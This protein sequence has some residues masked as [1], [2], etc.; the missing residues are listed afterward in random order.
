MRGMNELWRIRPMAS[1]LVAKGDRVLAPWT[2]GRG[3]VQRSDP[4]FLS[5]PV[6]TVSHRMKDCRV[7]AFAQRASRFYSRR[8]AGCHRHHR[9]AAAL[10]PG[11]RA[12]SARRP[13]GVPT[14]SNRSAWRSTRIT[15]RSRP[16]RP[17]VSVR[18][19]AM[20]AFAV[21][22]SLWPSPGCKTSRKT[23]ASL[24]VIIPASVSS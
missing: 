1:R 14:T 11:C 6:P 9:R 23:S 16:C 10:A 13:I 18:R 17:A 21:L 2:L 3:R 12:K 15:I 19:E 4:T 20:P 8:I 22:G 5:P 7:H 24:A